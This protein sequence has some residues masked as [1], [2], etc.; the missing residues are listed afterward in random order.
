MERKWERRLKAGAHCSPSL[1][2]SSCMHF[3]V[4]RDGCDAAPR[5]R[6]LA[7]GLQHRSPFSALAERLLPLLSCGCHK[8]G[9]S[10]LAGL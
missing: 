9:T 4:S 3:Q 1:S 8:Q 10:Y 7:F 6:P 2:A 5:G